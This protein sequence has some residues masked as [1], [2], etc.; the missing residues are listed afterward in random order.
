MSKPP[1]FYRRQAPRALNALLGEALAPVLRQRGFA[2]SAVMTQWREIVGQ[3][4]AE[5]TTPLELRWP[6]R[7]E[8]E[9]AAALNARR[10]RAEQATLV[11]ACPG[12]FALEVQMASAEIIAAVNCRLGFGAVGTLLIKQAPRPARAKAAPRPQ[13]DA[14]AIAA[15]ERELAGIEA[16]GLRRALAQLGAQVRLATLKA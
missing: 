3:R 2:T 7:H 5:W 6:R 4:L 10:Q 12:P 8:G 9:P 1:H 16:E 15:V 13:P 14:A 11:L